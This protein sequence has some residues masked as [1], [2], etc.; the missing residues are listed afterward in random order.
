MILQPTGLVALLLVLRREPLHLVLAELGQ[1]ALKDLDL[2]HRLCARTLC[3][4]GC[5]GGGQVE[6][7]G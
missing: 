4:E 1:V 2:D 5:R 6:E 7:R 3:T